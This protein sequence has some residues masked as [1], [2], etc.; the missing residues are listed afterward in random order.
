MA[1]QIFYSLSVNNFL[2]QKNLTALFQLLQ[3]KK[4]RP[5]IAK[6]IGLDEVGLS[7]R[8]L[9]HGQVRGTVI[10]LPWKRI[11][12]EKICWLDCDDTE[13]PEK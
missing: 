7:H 11:P 6:R 2:Q 12:R 5:Q 10:C 4:I 13:R 1:Y 3:L 8:K 9:E